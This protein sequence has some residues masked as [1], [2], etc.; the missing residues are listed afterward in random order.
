MDFFPDYPLA[1]SG[2]L[3][4]AGR[5]GANRMRGTQFALLSLSMEITLTWV[6]D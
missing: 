5:W 6:W 2:I 1:L 4:K 3:A